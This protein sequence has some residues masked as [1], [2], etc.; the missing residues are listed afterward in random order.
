MYWDEDSIEALFAH[1]AEDR[2]EQ[3]EKEEGLDT[4]IKKRTKPKEMLTPLA[5]ILQPNFAD[6]LKK[7]YT[8]RYGITPPEWARE[9]GKEGQVADIFRWAP[10]DFVRFVGSV[11]APIAP[12]A[13]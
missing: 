9:A 10:E 3:L 4:W 6:A 2:L 11:V 8:S 5:L 12:R 7:N 13:D 1:E